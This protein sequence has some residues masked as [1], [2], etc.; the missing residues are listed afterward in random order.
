MDG[1]PNVFRNNRDSGES[2]SVTPHGQNQIM[3]E[4]A[5]AERSRKPNKLH[6]AKLAQIE[7]LRADAAERLNDDLEPGIPGR[8]FGSLCRGGRKDRWRGR[9]REHGS[10]DD[11]LLLH[12]A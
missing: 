11:P 9:F 5:R 1:I 12:V 10:A 4:A 3:D 6:L 7:G 2:E 8:G